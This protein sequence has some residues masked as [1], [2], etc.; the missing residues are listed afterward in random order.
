MSFRRSAVLV[1]HA[2]YSAKR[3]HQRRVVL[4]V[5]LI[6]TSFLVATA[7]P[8]PAAAADPICTKSDQLQDTYLETIDP[9]REQTIELYWEQCE[10]NRTLYIELGD[11]PS[12]LR[13]VDFDEGRS[14]SESDTGSVTVVADPVGDT[15]FYETSF[16]FKVRHHK[17][18]FDDDV[19]THTVKVTVGKKPAPTP[20]P[21][22]PSAVDGVIIGIGPVLNPP[23]PGPEQPDQAPIDKDRPASDPDQKSSDPNGG[24]ETSNDNNE[25]SE[26]GSNSQNEGDRGGSQDSTE[27]GDNSTSGGDTAPAS[28]KPSTSSPE[29]GVL[30]GEAPITEFDPSTTLYGS[31]GPNRNTSDAASVNVPDGTYRVELESIGEN[32]A[33]G[34]QNQPNEQWKLQGLN[35]AGVVVYESPATN[36]LPDDKTSDTTT[37]DNQQIAGVVE[38]RAVHAN[39]DGPTNSI[40]PG[41][42]T[43]TLTPPGETEQQREQRIAAPSR[44]DGVI[45]RADQLTG[46]S[47]GIRWDKVDSA[48]SY[49]VYRNGDLLESVDGDASSYTVSGL[50]PGVFYEFTVTAVDSDGDESQQVKVGVRTPTLSSTAVTVGT[51]IASIPLTSCYGDDCADEDPVMQGCDNDAQTIETATNYRDADWELRYSPT[52]N[53]AW[54]RVTSNTPLD[55]YAHAVGYNCE[56]ADETCVNWVESVSIPAGRSWTKMISGFNTKM[57]VCYGQTKDNKPFTA[58]DTAIAPPEQKIQAALMVGAEIAVLNGVITIAQT[59]NDSSEPID[60][61]CVRKLKKTIDT[62]TFLFEQNARMEAE[63]QD[64]QQKNETDPT[65][66]TTPVGDD[67]PVN[68]QPPTPTTQNTPTTTAPSNEAPPVTSDGLEARE[69]WV[70]CASGDGFL[71][72]IFVNPV[73]AVG[74]KVYEIG[75]VVV[76]KGEYVV[77]ET[78]EVVEEVTVEAWEITQIL[79]QTLSDVIIGC[80]RNGEDLYNGIKTLYEDAVAFGKNPKKFV[81]DKIDEIKMIAKALHEDPKGFFKELGK[82]FVDAELWE[83]NPFQWVGKMV[84]AAVIAYF[85]GGKVIV[86]NKVMRAVELLRRIDKYIGEN[87]RYDPKT[88]DAEIPDKAELDRL[89]KE[90]KKKQDESGEKLDPKTPDLVP[91]QGET[92]SF[93]TNTQI[94]MGDGTLK[95]IQN[96]SP[97]D[98]V[99]AANPRTGV[100][101][102]QTVLDQWSHTDTGQLVTA[103]LE[104]GSTTTATDHH[105]YWVNNQG[106]WIE[107][108]DI[109]PGDQLLTPDG[110]TTVKKVVEHPI[111]E[112]LVWELD[113]EG[114]DTYTVWTGSRDVVVH[115]IEL[116]PI[117]NWSDRDRQTIEAETELR[118]LDPVPPSRLVEFLREFR[119]MEIRDV[120]GKR[121]LLD[122][123]A[124]TYI[125]QRHHPRFYDPAVIKTYNT[126]FDGSVSVER[127]H[128][129]MQETLRK[130]KPHPDKENTTLQIIDGVMYE[131]TIDPIKGRVAN[132][133]APQDPNAPRTIELREKLF[134]R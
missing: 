18:G 45:V 29:P 95:P 11:L 44:P 7:R 36:D 124:I 60:V 68:A 37:F 99:Q 61:E 108:A 114:P 131:L 121:L 33:N 66:T 30:N 53:A 62:Q 47:A 102:T 97:G 132:H 20:E 84:C 15:G 125:L 78:G 80:L 90:N 12:Q 28:D 107:L 39:P 54:T 98:T 118:G 48:E 112:T 81:N 23:A 41:K 56:D 103:T 129:M 71:T 72:R 65:K 113:V 57:G 21:E 13:K 59:I 31:G 22:P 122:K 32:H 70:P 25:T 117:G 2:I 40:T 4:L 63:K 123:G 67:K 75:E 17:L 110:I 119:T 38:F 43:L 106:E 91:C 82:D 83:D 120:N 16:T 64:K 94:R 133:F 126:S 104:D 51:G 115:N 101:S 93:P 86:F 127:L 77:R 116:C 27:T 42:V 69:V 87:R 26:S 100:W 50:Q 10:D 1:R 58:C 5:Y 109:K 46:T 92:N 89:E 52:C 79:A 111:V 134:P 85:T 35:E 6:I 49:N 130:G 14:K 76:E 9:G 74:N 8:I 3:L 96:I 34:T 19:S 55:G 88:P 128:V 73:K 105:E 24:N